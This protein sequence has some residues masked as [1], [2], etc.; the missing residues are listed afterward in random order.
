[1]EKNFLFIQF[2]RKLIKEQW[3]ILLFTLFLAYPV[4]SYS[5]GSRG[6]SLICETA[7][8]LVKNQD[9]KRF[10]ISKTQAITYLCNLPD[11]Y[12]R[13]IPG[14]ESGNST[15]FFEPDLIAMNF[16]QV[17]ID[18]TSFSNQ[19]KGK[20][21][22]NSSQPVLSVANELGTS[23]WRADQFSRLAIESGKMA[24][25]ETGPKDDNNSLYKMWV[26][27]S[28]MG[29]FIGDN[30]Q[31]YHNTR[32]Y[33]GWLTQHG[34]IHKFYETDLVN[35][36]PVDIISQVSKK[37]NLLT[38]KFQL[39]QQKNQS[40]NLLLER[41]KQLSQLSYGDLEKIIQLDPI[42]KPSK[43]IKEKGM[44]LKT[45]AERKSASQSIQKFK[46]LLILHMARG[47]ALLA[48]T[49]DDIYEASEKPTLQK[50]NQYQFP[51]QF[52][53]IAPDYVQ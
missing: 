32:D 2:Q 27:M 19:A 23:W 35:E 39:S 33:D 7:I 38:K 36:L 28:I 10:L 24:S 22:L 21:N 42:I 29:H 16:D 43:L 26:L 34:G 13:N 18:F 45:P 48:L 51:H 8:H 49:W 20:T 44:E 31:P 3:L 46:D 5:W 41:M 52:E 9:L 17:S 47:A 40:S 37:A 1:M 53:F 14:T 11:T 6:H 30:S 12:W 4:P 25:K 50:D 15:H